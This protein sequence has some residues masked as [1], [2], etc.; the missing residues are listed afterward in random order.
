MSTLNPV[1]EAKIVVLCYHAANISGNSYHDN[2]HVALSQDLKLIAQLGYPIV[3]P[4]A[5]ALLAQG[6]YSGPRRAVA[7]TFDDGITLDALDF[8]HPAHGPQVSMLNIL[9]EHRDQTGLPASA[10]SFVIASPEARAELDKKD[11]LS[12]GVWHDAW[13]REATQSGLLTIE[14]HSWDHNHPSLAST[15]APEGTKGNFAAIVDDADFNVQIDTAS[16]YIE[17]RA[18]VRPKLFAYPWGQGSEALVKNYLP[19]HGRNLGLVGAFEGAPSATSSS[20]DPWWI[21][22]AICGQ[23]WRHPGEL[24]QLLVHGLA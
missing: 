20:T 8:D 13:W 11:F 23:H 5:A 6:T 21:P 7:L 9:R 14:S 10:A 12:L 17:S 16:D 19:A 15:V 24:R 4:L 2:D 3:H 22:R 1:G 18:G